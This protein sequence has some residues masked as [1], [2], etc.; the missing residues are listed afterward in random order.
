MWS[1]A[2]IGSRPASD[3]GTAG[4]RGDGNAGVGAEL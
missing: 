1:A 2:G 3:P 4:A